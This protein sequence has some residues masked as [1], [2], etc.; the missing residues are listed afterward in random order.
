V[1]DTAPICIIPARGGSKRLPRKNI[2]D[3]DGKPIIVWTI[4]QAIKTGVFEKVIVSTEDK[5]IADTVLKWT[6]ADV[7][8]RP[9]SLATDT[10]TV[11]EVCLDVL[12]KYEN[13]LPKNFCCLYATSILRSVADITESYNMLCNEKVDSVMTITE[14][15]QYPHQALNIND[16]CEISIQW[17][18]LLMMKRQIRPHLVVDA[19]S[20]YWA[21]TDAFIENKNFYCDS[22]KGFQVPRNRAI[23]V[24][25]E[26]DLEILM[27]YWNK[28]K[29][30]NHT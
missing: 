21:N 11:D 18:E 3:V 15:E 10:S 12:T 25:V 14:Y 28:N 27:F 23:D 26:E 2:I 4:E 16:N 24:D 30:L 22:M 6:A 29:K 7:W 8:V 20:I 13:K 9:E 17:P 5:I 19:G 1:I